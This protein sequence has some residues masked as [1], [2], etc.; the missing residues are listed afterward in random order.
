MIDTHSLLTARSDATCPTGRPVLVVIGPSASGKSSVVRTLFD[1]GLVR[2]HPTWT[3]RPRRADEVEGTLEHRF[4]SERGFDR[5]EAAGF[6]AATTRMFGLPYRYGLPPVHPGESGPVDLVMLRASLVDRFRSLVPD[7]LVY[8]VEDAPDRMRARLLARSTGPLDAAARLTDNEREQ[9]AGWQVADRIFRN[10]GPV[11][12]L[13]LDV[14][15]AIATDLTAAED[16]I[17]RDAR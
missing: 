1:W 9:V 2:V 3:T 15:R 4:V 10:A 6:F 16:R 12:G 14:A 13:A 8:Q 7:L 5:L 17:V 11:D